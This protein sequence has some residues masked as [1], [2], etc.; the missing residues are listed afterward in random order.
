MDGG[1][2]SRSIDESN[3]ASPKTQ[4]VYAIGS[5]HSVREQ[6]LDTN[7]SSPK[8]VYAF[9]WDQTYYKYSNN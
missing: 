3:S 2:S 5:S 6:D 8:H 7:T 9:Q 4:H 1:G